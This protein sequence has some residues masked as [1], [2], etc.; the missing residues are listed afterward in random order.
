MR[1]SGTELEQARRVAD[2]NLLLKIALRREQR[3]EIDEVAVIGHH[4]D[5]RMRP[6]GSPDHAIT[7]G[8]DDLARKGHGVDKGWT[9]GGDALT[10]ADLDPAFLVA[11]HQL[12]QRLE[13]QL[14]LAVGR[15]DAAHVIDG[16]AYRQPRQHL[17]IFGDVDR[18][19]VQVDMPV[20]RRDHVDHA[21]KYP[22]VRHPAEMADEIEAA[23]AKAAVMQ[24]AQ[25]A[26][27]YAVI[28]VGNC[29]IRAVAHRNRIQCDTVVGAVYTGIH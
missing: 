1:A 29:S 8:L 21:L 14:T 27:A 23:A 19:E 12:D 13:R 15:L 28:D 2:Q 9:D 25:T 10:A 17:G 4:L 5:V 11:L 20:E 16:V 26:L 18:I 6:I 3:H 22:L 24:L 7:R